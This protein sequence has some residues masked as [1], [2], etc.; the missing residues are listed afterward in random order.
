M[1]RSKSLKVTRSPVV[2]SR[3][4]LVHTCRKTYHRLQRC[5]R[6]HAASPAT[7][8]ARPRKKAKRAVVEDPPVSIHYETEDVAPFNPFAA[9]PAEAVVPNVCALDLPIVI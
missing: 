6:N 2:E 9:D 3:F 5:N 4:V 1:G 8:T 7:P